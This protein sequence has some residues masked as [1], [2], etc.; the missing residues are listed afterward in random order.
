V[1]VVARRKDAEEDAPSKAILDQLQTKTVGAPPSTT[2]LIGDQLPETIFNVDNFDQVRNQVTLQLTNLELLNVLN[3]IGQ[4]TN[5]QSQSGPIPNTQII[6][7]QTFT[8]VGY[9]TFLTPEKGQVWQLVGAS[10]SSSTGLSGTGIIEIDITNTVTGNRVVVSDFN[11]TSSSDFPV[12]ESGNF[13]P[14]FIDG[15]NHRCTIRAEGTFTTINM[16]AC[17]IRVR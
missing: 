15:N 17:F 16:V 1:G 5:T 13:Q 2:G 3:T 11:F 6:E 4:V 8:S 12:V 10:V 9:R 7:A 14:V